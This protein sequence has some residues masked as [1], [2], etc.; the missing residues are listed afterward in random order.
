MQSICIAF[1]NSFL[2][3]FFTILF[4]DKDQ[5]TCCDD[6]GQLSIDATTNP[7]CAPI[8]IPP[9]DPIH[10]PQGTQCM[11]FVRTGT[12]RGRGCTTPDTVA[13]PVSGVLYL[14]ITYIT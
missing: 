13:E 1:A 14:H 12:T 8:L 10:G 7:S 9:N 6:N 11:N 5:I 3:I 2:N 4:T